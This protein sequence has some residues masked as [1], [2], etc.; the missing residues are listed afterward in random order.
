MQQETRGCKQEGAPRHQPAGHCWLILPSCLSRR[1]SPTTAAAVC[2]VACR[3]AI[4]FE[5]PLP[6]RPSTCRI[7]GVDVPRVFSALC[8]P[9]LQLTGGLKIF[10]RGICVD[11]PGMGPKTHCQIASPPRG[12]GEVPTM[13][14]YQK[15]GLD[16]E[17]FVQFFSSHRSATGPGRIPP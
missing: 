2:H 14:F 4:D 8:H 6:L 5:S 1:V 7:T 15:S 13:G 11:R 12:G 3:C 10:S 16:L 17:R 9:L